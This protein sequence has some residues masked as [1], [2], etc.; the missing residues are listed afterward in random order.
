MV[1]KLLEI[2]NNNCNNVDVDMVKKAYHFAQEAHKEQK[3]NQVNLIS[4]IQ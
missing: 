1:D 3:E 2:I 4:F